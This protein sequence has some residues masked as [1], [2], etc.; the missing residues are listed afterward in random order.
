ML[1]N[2]AYFPKQ[3]D[4]SS[5]GTDSVQTSP[6]DDP[7]V[8]DSKLTNK[9]STQLDVTSEP[10]VCPYLCTIACQYH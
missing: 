5:S 8:K 6:A 4:A 2:V 7:G 1:Y 9:D 3:V 10:E